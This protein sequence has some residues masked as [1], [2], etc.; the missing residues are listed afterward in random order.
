[1]V[2]KD[3]LNM[4][5]DHFGFLPFVWKFKDKYL[6]MAGNWFMTLYF[7]CFEL[8]YITIDIS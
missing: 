4:S 6:M 2:Y 7:I 1:M 3:F 5:V 8:K